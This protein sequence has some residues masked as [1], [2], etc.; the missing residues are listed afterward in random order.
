M[1][2][3]TR[4]VNLLGVLAVGVT[5]RMRLAVAEAMP[6]G[7]NRVGGNRDRARADDVHRSA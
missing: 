2:L 7:G 3:K 5:D 6:L 4:L 1:A